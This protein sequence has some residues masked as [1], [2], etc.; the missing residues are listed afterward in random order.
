MGVILERP[1]ELQSTF[2]NWNGL[3]IGT[4]WKKI[5]PLH[6]PCFVHI[7]VFILEHPR[8]PNFRRPW[9]FQLS[10]VDCNSAGRSNITPVGNK[11]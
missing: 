7:L 8:S 1:A 10:R 4:I 5:F 9:M 3:V 2:D 11:I 6:S